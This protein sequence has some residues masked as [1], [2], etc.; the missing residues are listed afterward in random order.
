MGYPTVLLHGMWCTE[1][2]MARLDNLL[3]ARTY[4]CR[5][6]SLPAHTPGPQQAGQ[7][8]ALSIRE[9]V[10]AAGAFIQTQNFT[11]PPILVGHSMGGLLAQLLAPGVQPAALVLLTPAAPAGVNSVVPAALPFAFPILARWG[12]WK[13]SHGL[14]PE[15]ARSLATNGL[16]RERQDSIYAGLLQDS[17]R[18]LSEIAFWWAD[19][20]H[21]TRVDAA[22][23]TCPVYVVS[24][25][26]DHLIPASVVRKVAAR[27]PGA[28]HRHWPERGHWVIDD[29]D[30]EDMVH[31]IDGWLRPILQRASRVSTSYTNR[32]LR[33]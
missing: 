7:V 30:S 20:Q 29:L 3:S 31:E 14:T 17:G 2:H 27:Y 15:R 13:K 11:Q 33:A 6:F 8:A 5:R 25:G 4:D 18:V 10:K 23:V 28:T 22:L 24:A 26:K 19:S 16:S 9:Y 32:G 1:Q 12:F 21:S